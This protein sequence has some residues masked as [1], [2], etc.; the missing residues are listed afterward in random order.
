MRA[1]RNAVKIKIIHKLREYRKAR[2]RGKRS[3]FD[4]K[5]YVKFLM[6]SAERR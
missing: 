3:L 6:F 5:R 1:L 4:L 2:Q